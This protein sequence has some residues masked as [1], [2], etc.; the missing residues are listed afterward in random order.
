MN[1]SRGAKAAKLTSWWF[2]VAVWQRTVLQNLKEVLELAGSSLEKV[3]KYNVY[4]ADM[5]D[6]AEMNKVYIEVSL[7]LSLLSRRTRSLMPPFPP[8]PPSSSPSPCLPDP[9]FR[10]SLRVLGR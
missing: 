8:A 1:L 9:A 6:F 4:L 10:P 5:K 7:V 3:V 2:G